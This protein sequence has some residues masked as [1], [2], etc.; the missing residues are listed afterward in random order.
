MDEKKLVAFLRQSRDILS[1]FFPAASLALLPV[2]FSSLVWAATRRGEVKKKIMEMKVWLEAE[3]LKNKPAEFVLDF[4]V[5]RPEL[6]AVYEEQISNRDLRTLR[7]AFRALYPVLGLQDP[8]LEKLFS[9]E[10]KGHDYRRLVAEF[11]PRLE[12]ALVEIRAAGSRKDFWKTLEGVAEESL[13]LGWDLLTDDQVREL[14]KR[15]ME[16]M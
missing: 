4:F 6:K 9:A 11:R 16:K 10:L 14:L 1:D 12:A 8:F 15:A 7:P 5:A 2:I 13:D 3:T